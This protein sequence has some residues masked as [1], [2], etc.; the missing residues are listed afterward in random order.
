MFMAGISGIIPGANSVAVGAPS[1]TDPYWSNVKLLLGFGG[2]DG[3]ST[4]TDESPTAKGDAGNSTGAQVDTAQAKFGGSSLL[5]DGVDDRISYADNGDWTFTSSDQWTVECWARFNSLTGFQTFISHWNT[6]LGAGQGS[7]IFDFPGSTN[8]VLRFSYSTTGSNLVA[9]QG[10]WTPSANTWYHVAA[11]CDATN[12]L[13]IYVDG[14]MIASATSVP[15]FFNSNY[16][17]LVGSAH[18]PGAENYFNGWLD[19]VRVTKGTAR[20]AS[21][22]G[23]SVPTAAFPRS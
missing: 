16:L 17:L 2:A 11:D 9:V 14:V 6:Q 8:N 22:S 19:E 10:S 4:V 23:Y 1:G 3:S 13:R 18:L 15:S 7:W 21:D 5:L 12:K 20:Y